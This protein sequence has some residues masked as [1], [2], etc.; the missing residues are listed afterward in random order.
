MTGI[1][2]SMK[3]RPYQTT[4][5]QKITGAFA[6]GARVVMAV[7]G[8]GGGKTA[9]F[10]Y[11]LL[12]HTGCCL[13][14]AH[15]QE[16]VRQMS[17]TLAKYGVVHRIIGPDAL[18][19]RIIR[20]QIRVYGRDYYDPSSK[21]AVAG[22]DTIIARAESLAAWLNQVTFWVGDEGHHFSGVKGTVWS[23]GNK[24]CRA[25]ALMPNACGLLV[26]A[27]PERADGRGLGVG[28]DGIVDI[29]VE[30]PDERELIDAGYLCNYRVFCPS[31]TLDVH[32]I[33]IGHDGD[34]N[35]KQL[36]LR[37]KNSTVIG[38]IV[39]YYTKYASGKKWATFMP[40]VETA[41]L[42]AKRFNEAGV[43]AEVITSQTPDD[44]R[45]EILLKLDRKEILQIVNVDILGEGFDCPSLE[46]I[47]MGRYTES[48]PLFHQ[49]AMRSCRIDPDNPDKL[50]IIFDHVGNF[51]RHGVPDR[52][53]S[54]TLNRRERGA[55]GQRDPDVPLTRTCLNPDVGGGVPCMQPYPR[56]LDACPYCGH[57]PIPASRSSVEFVDGCLYE[58]DPQVLAAMRGAVQAVDRH[59]DEVLRAMQRAGAPPPAAYGAA[60]QHEARQRAQ[61]VLREAM[62]LWGGYQQAMG[63]S[64]SEA[65]RRWWHRYGVDVL[66]A[67]ALGRPEA[68]ALTARVTADICKLD[69]ELRCGI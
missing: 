31:S 38:D 11:V 37:T 22:V 69:E 61:T 18:I 45:F 13:A 15:R 27:T 1:T 40:D 51:H 20:L 36:A 42:I 35:R 9:I 46:G 44:V 68:E 14:M 29:M 63:R 21:C 39:E 26:T 58:L 24:W 47:S 62:A 16:L 30:G 12:C 49:Q 6:A 4:L 54:W 48:Y 64:L 2:D 59:P 34:V 23:T 25:A 57:I 3:L 55:R 7:L 52:R 8:C 53:H 43:P 50:A 32:D 65:Q 41:T 17:M 10:C 66:S 19:K 5:Y 60:K 67:Q 33:T 28:Q 56:Y